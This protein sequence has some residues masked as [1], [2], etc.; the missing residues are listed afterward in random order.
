MTGKL[1]SQTA[2][3]T[4]LCGVRGSLKAC[5]GGSM[6]TGSAARECLPQSQTAYSRG[7]NP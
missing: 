4:V 3:G 6:V 7:S 2:N 5:F 1:R